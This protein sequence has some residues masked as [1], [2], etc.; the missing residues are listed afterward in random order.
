MLNSLTQSYDF[1]KDN[2]KVAAG[3]GLLISAI[4]FAGYMWATS[5]D[6]VEQRVED[7]QN[8][9]DTMPEYEQEFDIAP[10]TGEKESQ[11]LS[12]LELLN[13]DINTISK[14]YDQKLHAHH[15][16]LKKVYNNL[17]FKSFYGG[18]EIA[19]ITR[20]VGLYKTKVQEL[21]SYLEQHKKFIEGYQIINEVAQLSQKS[22]HNNKNEIVKLA[23]SHDS[24]SSFPLV[25]YLKKIK[26]DLECI[27]FLM[28]EKIA[29]KDYPTLSLMKSNMSFLSW[30][31]TST[32][33]WQN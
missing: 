31:N 29:Q 27:E 15:A 23:K 17:W 30:K 26:Q 7:A 3:S 2:L 11:I 12:V 6:S 19:E 4:A 10:I 22:L 24:K 5:G 1:N 28:T 8:E 21:L 32:K 13:I 9:L 20:K 14:S 25:M 16:T 33:L 18:Q